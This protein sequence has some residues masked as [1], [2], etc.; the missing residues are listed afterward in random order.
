MY[1]IEMNEATRLIN[2]TRRD[3]ENS[4]AQRQRA[5]KDL[6]DQTARYNRIKNSRETDRREIDAL[7]LRISENE[8]VGTDLSPSMLILSSF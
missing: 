3:A 7:Q 6:R 4:N 5:E 1:D 2:D 8:A